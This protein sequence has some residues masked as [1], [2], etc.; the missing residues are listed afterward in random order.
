MKISPKD[1]KLNQTISRISHPKKEAFIQYYRETRG[2]ISD[3]ARAVG[4]ARRTY[5]DWLDNDPRFAL[6]IAEAEA[7][8]SDDMRKAL[9][10]KGGEGDLG[11]IIFWLKNRHP[12]F[13]P[14]PGES[15]GYTQN[16]YFN[17]IKSEKSEFE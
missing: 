9:I 4:V 12:D 8:I 10:D 13:R 3:C 5:Y 17:M 7:E 16:N 2:H 11:A 15:G 6:V 14:K 1:N